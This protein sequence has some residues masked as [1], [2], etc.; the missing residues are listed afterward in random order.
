ME[1]IQAKLKDCIEKQT[2]KSL[3]RLTDALDTRTDDNAML[4]GDDDNSS[5]SIPAFDA[6]ETKEPSEIKGENKVIISKRSKRKQKH[7]YRMKAIP[8]ERK[9]A[10]EK[11]VKPKPR[12]HCAF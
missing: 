9:H 7:G 4:E 8:I 10:P 2:L 5:K 11:A 6:S 3:D 12:F 1:K